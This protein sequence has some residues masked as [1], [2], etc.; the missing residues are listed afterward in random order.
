MEFKWEHPSQTAVLGYSNGVSDAP[1]TS[2]ATIIELEYS[3]INFGSQTIPTSFKVPRS[4]LLG[5]S[6]QSWWKTRAT[7]NQVPMEFVQGQICVG[8]TTGFTFLVRWTCEL[9]G[10]IVGAATPAPA[11]VT[12]D[13]APP[14]CGPGS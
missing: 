13:P 10:W 4:Y 1:P 7:A 8:G 3:D 6:N 5:Q 14:M 2:D 9:S 11:H 12:V